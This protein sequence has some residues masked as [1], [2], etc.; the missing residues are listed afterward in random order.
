M[1]RIT[2]LAPFGE[3]KVFMRFSACSRGRPRG[4][5]HLIPL[6]KS[7]G[8]PR[9]CALKRRTTLLAPF[10]ERKVIMHFSL[11]HMADR[12]VF[13][14]LIPP[15]KSSGWPRLCAL[16]RRTTLLPPF[17]ERKVVMRFSACSRG[18]SRGFRSSD[19]NSKVPRLATPVRAQAPHYF[20]RA[21]R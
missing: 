12:A 17:G 18:R 6:P 16:K 8:W 11:G 5:V 2:L 1:R 13:V 21:I 10:G 20:A 19:A 14:H 15:P 4:L 9:L 7:S 3:R